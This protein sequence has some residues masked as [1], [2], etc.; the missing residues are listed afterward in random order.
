LIDKISG[1]DTL[2]N[3]RQINLSDNMIN[4]IEGL[5]NLPMLDTIQ[6][7]RNR[8]GRTGGLS[9]VVGLLE[10][11]TLTCVDISDNF[12]EDENIL[13]EVWTKLPNVLVIYMQG[14]GCTKKIKNYR[15]TVISSIP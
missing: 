1:L 14:N 15:K 13:T 9:D 11:P 7:K 10:C 12:I 6:L 3:L 2:C 8:I 4:K 5:G